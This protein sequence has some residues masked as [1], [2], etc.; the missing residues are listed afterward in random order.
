MTCKL[1]SYVLLVLSYSVR[2]LNNE[3]KCMRSKKLSASCEFIS[4]FC[5]GDTRLNPERPQDG[6]LR[7]GP[8]LT[9][10]SSLDLD[11]SG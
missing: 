8:P 11:A 10:V 6:Y 2:P 4:V 9:G 3:Y 1:L 7:Y 5:I